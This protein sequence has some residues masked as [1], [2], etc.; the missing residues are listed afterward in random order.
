MATETKAPRSET[1][2]ANERPR[3]LRVVKV[4]AYA[5]VPAL[6]VGSVAFGFY[7]TTGAGSQV[8]QRL[9]AFDLPKLSGGQ[10]SDRDLNGHPVVINFWASWCL[11][12]RDEAP[13][14]EAKWQKY[15]DEGLIVLG[16]NAKDAQEDASRFVDE[17]D[18]SFPIVRDVEL[19]LYRKLGVRGMPETF[20]LDRNSVFVAV[21]SQEQVGARGS[22][23]VLG[24]VEPAALDSQIQKLLADRD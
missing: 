11:P 24:P 1:A 14:L 21:G 18:L 8:G 13:T 17:F 20:F 5:V 19:Q 16:V 22:I 7:K 6:F 3:W 9:P 23:K 2:P 4:L 10:L 12:C 15:K